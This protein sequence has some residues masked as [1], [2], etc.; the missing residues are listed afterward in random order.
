MNSFPKKYNRE[1]IK[2]S[3]EKKESYSQNLYSNSIPLNQKLNPGCIF[4]LYYKDMYTR[5]Q[6]IFS[7]DIGTVNTYN[8][9]SNYFALL[10]DNHNKAKSELSKNLKNNISFL[11]KLWL[12]FDDKDNLYALSENFNRY[13]RKIFVDLSLHEKI[14][15]SQQI[16]YRS[17]EMQTNFL[18][19]NIIEK[20]TE[21]EWYTIKY[22]IEAKWQTINIPT[23]R[24][25]SLFWDVAIAVNPI[26]KRYKKLVWQNV[27]VPI[28]NK[29]IP[30]IADESVDMCIWEWAIRITPAHDERSLEIAKKNWLPTNIYSFDT[31]WYFTEN[32]W[33]FQ[34]KKVSEFLENIVKYVEDIWNMENQY[35]TKEIRYFDSYTWNELVPM[36]LCQWNI[37]YDY[38]K[39]VLAQLLLSDDLFYN[40]IWWKWNLLNILDT[41]YNNVIS[42]SSSNGILIPV[43]FHENDSECFAINDDVIISRYESSKN[44]K[45]IVMTLIILNLILDNNLPNTFTIQDLIDILYS[46]DFFSKT[47]KLEKYL[48]IYENEWKINWTYK[49]WI[50]SV[51]RLMESIDKNIENVSDL[52]DILKNS[53]A[54]H[55]DDENISINYNELFNTSWLY[56]QRQDCF[57]KAFI[58]SCLSM[59][60]K[61]L[62]YSSESYNNLTKDNSIFLSTNQEK[63]LFFDEMLL[64]IE[65]AKVV[66]YM[67]YITHP[68]LLDFKKQK[69]NNYNSKF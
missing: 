55:F 7:K 38:A 13:I 5:I 57:N 54:I 24:I 4:S 9:S 34:W 18:K 22:F 67:S 8:M 41:E 46:R 32:A 3:K 52:I 6:N 25:E 26:D 65:Y 10:N 59:Y 29:N 47:T 17:N 28:I 64:N 30:I 50:K 42:N 60:C 48:E 20:N 45:D 62:V 53:F 33:E 12:S 69:I 11:E 40:W 2:V 68:Y 56:L 37:N 35:T 19:N 51:R 16:T 49:I 14:S 63:Y 27:I 43:I 23:T 66:P 36:S 58:D 39:D 1:N 31:N 21:V 44:K 61:W 15:S